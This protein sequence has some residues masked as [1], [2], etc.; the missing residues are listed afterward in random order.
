MFDLGWSELILIGVVA[1]I[2]IG[3]KELPSVL[4]MIGQWTAKIRRMATEFQG[5]FS[6]ALREAEMVDLKKQVEDIN[7]TAR[8]ITQFNPLAEP[9]N[10][11]APVADAGES[12]LVDASSPQPPLPAVNDVADA[13][14]A[15]PLPPDA[16]GAE[17]PA[18]PVEPEATSAEPPANAGALSTE[19]RPTP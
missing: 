11:P 3:P 10:K 8:S 7:E 18:E 15:E 12:A 9:E 19:P 6:E 2:V 17:P 14:A 5:Q 13:T 1:L 16:G 4:R